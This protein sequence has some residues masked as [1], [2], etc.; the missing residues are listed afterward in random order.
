MSAFEKLMHYLNEEVGFHHPRTAT[1]HSDKLSTYLLEDLLNSSKKLQEYAKQKKIC[2]DFNVDV[3]SQI[4]SHIIDL[5]I[6]EYEPDSPIKKIHFIS[7]IEFL[8]ARP[9]SNKYQILIEHK[10]VITAHRNNKNRLRDLKEFASHV[11]LFD[12]KSVIA[13]TMMIGTALEY[14]S[15]ESLIRYL[16]SENRFEE[17]GKWKTKLCKGDPSLKNT[18]QGTIVITKN[19]PYEAQK[20][21]DL[22][23][24]EIP[25]RENIDEI[26]FDALFCLFVH[27]DNINPCRI[28][29]EKNTGK[30]SINNYREFLNRIICSYEQRY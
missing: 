17:L 2:F 6:G 18:F 27:I 30:D 19:K 12:K 8:Q 1:E 22:Y 4:S 13:A 20:T 24:S 23:K 11:Y 9:I 29:K 15:V 25:L 5:V 26:G 3:K 10:S 28:D 14:F 21:Y 7:G 16:K